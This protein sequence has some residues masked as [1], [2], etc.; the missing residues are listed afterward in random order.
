MPEPYYRKGFI[1]GLKPAITSF[2]K[3]EKVLCKF[4]DEIYF[5]GRK[6]KK[7]GSNY[8][9]VLVDEEEDTMD[10]NFCSN[11]HP[12]VDALQVFDES[13]KRNTFIKSNSW[14]GEG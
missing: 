6:C 2:E 1:K 7:M 12:L 8:L 14:F 3:W 11:N 10:N 5:P 9:V 4:C 13:P